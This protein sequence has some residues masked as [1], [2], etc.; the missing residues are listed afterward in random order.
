MKTIKSW[1]ESIE[2]NT[3]REKALAKLDSEV[4]DHKVADLLSAVQAAFDY[5]SP[6]SEEEGYWSEVHFKIILNGGTI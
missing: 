1:L 3:I 6:F 4:A 5:G 2:D